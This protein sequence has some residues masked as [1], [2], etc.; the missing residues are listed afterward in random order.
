MAVNVKRYVI[1][2][3]KLVRDR[4]PVD[5]R[6]FADL[7]AYLQV[8]AGPF[9]WL[10]NSFVLYRDRMIYRITITPQRCYLEK[11]L[12]DRYDNTL[13]RIY[14]GDGITYE[15]LY[16][17]REIELQPQFIYRE[18]EAGKP[19]SYL[20]NETEVGQVSFDFV[21]WVPAALTYN[22]SEMITL[23]NDYKLAS[24]LYTIETF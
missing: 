2:Y 9:I 11:M 23:I 13:R 4:V 24:K 7:M 1:D 10:H 18:S 19:A 15:P 16:I 22:A 5:L 20:F 12:N 17:Y 3:V 8:I 21:V 6:E 14:I